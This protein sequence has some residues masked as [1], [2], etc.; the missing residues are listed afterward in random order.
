MKE[1]YLYIQRINA[2]LATGAFTKSELSF[3]EFLLEN[4]DSVEQE[5]VNSIAVRSGLSPATV[6]RFCRKLGFSGFPEMKKSISLSSNYVED[7]SSD[8]ELEYGDSAEN[9][10]TKVISYSKMI[11]DQLLTS[12][13]ADSLQAAADLIS[14]AKHVVIVGEGGSGTISRAAYDIFLKLALPV[15]LAED[16]MFQMMEI[17]TMGPNDILFIIVN[18]GRTYNILE[19]AKYA[20]ER[21]IKTIGIVGPMN[22]PLSKYLDI[23]LNTYLFNSSYFS[24]ISAARLSEL[25]TVSILHSILALTRD[26]EQISISNEIAQALERKRITAGSRTETAAL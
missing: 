15:R 9:V 26:E 10:K 17:S 22:S 16:I 20:K 21:G 25:V 24:D 12:L 11:I 14:S 19:N 4:P 8:M 13:D 1:T 18:S 6:V 2:M 3:A 5:T 23:E 7:A